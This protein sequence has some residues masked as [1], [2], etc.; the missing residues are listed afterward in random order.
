M[1]GMRIGEGKRVEVEKGKGDSGEDIS[2]RYVYL[3]HDWGEIVICKKKYRGSISSTMKKLL[4][5]LNR[6]K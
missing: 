6:N 1:T 4:R 3:S 2:I 5:R